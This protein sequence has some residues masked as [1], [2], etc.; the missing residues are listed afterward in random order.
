VAASDL[1]Q[2]IIDLAGGERVA[3]LHALAPLP[4][5]GFPTVEDFLRASLGH[6]FLRLSLAELLLV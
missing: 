2:G 5:M 3:G 1:V 6:V 4:P